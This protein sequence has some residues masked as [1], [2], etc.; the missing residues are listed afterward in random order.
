MQEVSLI[1]LVN[2]YYPN[3]LDEFLSMLYKF[4]FTSIAKVCEAMATS[5]YSFNPL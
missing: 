1:V 4:N 3:Q 2:L 5:I